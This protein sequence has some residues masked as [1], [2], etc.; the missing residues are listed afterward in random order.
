MI[1]TI[2]VATDASNH[3]Q[4]AVKLA[5]E[6]ARLYKARLVIVHSLL[7]DA[8][9]RILRKLA[10][11]QELTRE[12]RHMLDNYEIDMQLTVAAAGGMDAYMAFVPAP[13]ELLQPIG[14][15][16]LGRAEK[17]ARAARVKSVS[18]KL[19]SGDPADGILAAAKKEK[20]NLIILGTRG[21]GE[22]KGFLLGSVSH[23]V[24]ARAHCPVLTMK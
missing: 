21:Y 9:S 12:Q 7:L 18:T 16:I 6:M 23:K 3:A 4:K 8:N 1:K 17:V 5:S 20:A 22:L 10:N 2:V 15:Q 14:R 24:S 13:I 19:L 11:R